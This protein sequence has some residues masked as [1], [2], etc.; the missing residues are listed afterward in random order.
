MVLCSPEKQIIALERVMADRKVSMHNSIT[1]HIHRM[2]TGIRE[3]QAKV[4]EHEA[5]CTA[6][7][8]PSKDW[9][10]TFSGMKINQKVQKAVAILADV[11][12]V[13]VDPIEIK[14]ALGGNDPF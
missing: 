11:I 4:G 3:L 9:T 12:L 10:I 2:D 7:V 5:E 14:P 8:N 1:Q 6:S 13:N